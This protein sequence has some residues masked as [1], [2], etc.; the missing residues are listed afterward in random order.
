[1]NREK[2]KTELNNI[3]LAAAFWTVFIVGQLI[4]LK[5]LD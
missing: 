3:L 2:I 1:M 5:V 4:L